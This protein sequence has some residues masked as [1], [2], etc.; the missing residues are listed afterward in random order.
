MGWPNENYGDHL[1]KIVIKEDAVYGILQHGYLAYYNYAGKELKGD[2]VK[3]NM[4][5]I[6]VVFHINERSEMITSRKR[7]KKNR[8]TFYRMV[9][10]G[11]NKKRKLEA[12]FREFVILNE[13]MITSYS[14]GT[15]EIKSYLQQQTELL[16]RLRV[17]LEKNKFRQKGWLYGRYREPIENKIPI[18]DNYFDAICFEND[19][20]LLQAETIGAIIGKMEQVLK[21]QGEPIQVKR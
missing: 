9:E 8:G 12:P 6:A 18:E 10:V 14:Y 17:Y 11:K 3:A 21:L 15:D 2:S 13:D 19:Y 1:V 20:Y 7:V 5:K 16:K 4:D